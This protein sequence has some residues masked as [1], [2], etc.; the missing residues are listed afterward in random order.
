MI[1]RRSSLHLIIAAAAASFGVTALAADASNEPKTLLAE[2]GTLLLS[3]DLNA[4]PSKEWRVAKGKWEAVDGAVQ[5]EEL[6]ADKHPGVMR[7]Q[8]K[9]Q[10]AIFQYSFKLDGAKQTTLSINDEKE[11]VC[12]VLIRPNG[13][14]VQKDDHDHDGPDKAVVFKTIATP[15]KEGEWHTVVVEILGEEMLASIDG[16]KVGFGAH[17]LIGTPKANFGLTVNG[18]K[19]SFKNLRVWEALPNKNW[20]ETKAKLASSDSAK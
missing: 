19:V 18:Q 8:L 10:N 15:I 14:T 20:A 1:T 4:A 9:F 3:D 6:P 16:D 5:G 13:F 11:H 7:R 17:E 2:R 12:R